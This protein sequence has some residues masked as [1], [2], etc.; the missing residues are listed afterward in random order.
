MISSR[1]TNTIQ[2][3]AELILRKL[4]NCRILSLDM[5]SVPANFELKTGLVYKNNRAIEIAD[6]VVCCSCETLEYVAKII[7]Q[8]PHLNPIK[9]R[10][11]HG[12]SSV[13]KPCHK[14]FPEGIEDDK[15]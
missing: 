8:A 3:Q 7:G 15:L 10:S 5:S 11:W 6:S 9:L 12:F 1:K 4:Y 2:L 14:I 13:I